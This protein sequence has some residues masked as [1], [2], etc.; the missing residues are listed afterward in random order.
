MTA[1]KQFRDGLIG[2][3]A[4]LLAICATITFA[5]AAVYQLTAPT[6][7]LREIEKESEARSRVL[8]GA[9][10]FTE[11]FGSFPDGVSEVFKADN[12][13]GYVMR[14]VTRGYGSPITFV[15]GIGS[16]GTV[17]GI[18]I[19][20]HNETP[21]LGSRISAEAYLSRFYGSVNHHSVD[22]ITGATISSNAL[23]TALG[24]AKEAYEIAKG[25]R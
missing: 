8:N 17:E 19:L 20:D 16:D 7:E 15:I 4:I 11:I 2:P 22:S 12:G 13:T 5:L 25:V 6:I 1:L 18:T 3:T 10:R 14:T 24:L 9:E 21:G 23:K